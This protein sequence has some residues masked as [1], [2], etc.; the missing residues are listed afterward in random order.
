MRITPRGNEVKAVVSL[1][2]SDEYDTA[3]AMAKAIIKRVAELFAER[4]WHAWVYRESPDAFYI[5]FGPFTSDTEAKRFAGRWVDALKGQHMILPLHSTAA[6]TAQ[7][8]A[9]KSPSHY[10]AECN[11]SLV[12]HQ[13]PKIQPKCAV[14]GCKC[15]R[16]TT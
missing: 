14:K 7:M 2:E 15:K 3:D 11:H 8:A 10:C 6:L 5:P 16:S 1:M 13:H 9:Y 4:E 12:S